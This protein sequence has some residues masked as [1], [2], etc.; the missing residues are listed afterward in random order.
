MHLRRSLEYGALRRGA[1]V[2]QWGC[3]VK[4]K[5]RGWALW[6]AVLGMLLGALA[7][8]PATAAP[9]D[10]PGAVDPSFT[11]TYSGF[12]ST[13]RSLV[14]QP[15]GKILAAGSFNSFNGASAPCLARFN[16]DWTIDTG[17]H[18]QSTC[19]HDIWSLALQPDGKILAS[20]PF[21]SYDNVPV[22]RVV[23][24]NSDGT[25]DPTFTA[26]GTGPDIGA[27]SLAVAP[28]GKII[29][30]GRFTTFDGTPTPGLARLEP[31]GTLDTAF[32]TNGG[33]GLNDRVADVAVQADGKVLAVGY[34]TA[35]DATTTNH[36]ARINTDGTLDTAF[37]ANGG[38]GL[39]KEAFTV[40]V[41]PDDKIVMGG[42]FTTYG[43]RSAKG[44]VRLESDGTYDEA[45]TD[46][47]P[48]LNCGI[49][50]LDL[51][52][53][54]IVFTGYFPGVTGWRMGRLDSGGAMDP[55]FNQK[56]GPFDDFPG[57]VASTGGGFVVG[58][59]FDA[60]D[61]QAAFNIAGF[62]ADGTLVP[63]PGLGFNDSVDTVQVLPDQKLLVGGI[64]D[65]YGSTPAHKVARLNPDG[66]LD[67]SFGLP[68]TGFKGRV[69]A[70][71]PL[72]NGDFYAGGYIT[73]FN[74]TPVSHL[75]RLHADGT[76]DTSFSQMGK[77]LDAA[78]YRAVVQPDGKLLVA[79]EFTA[80]DQTTVPHLARFNPDGS[81]DTAFTV[82]GGSGA[83]NPVSAVALLP[84]GKIVI[85]GRFTSFDGQKR[86]RIAR[87]NADGSLDTT[88]APTGAGFDNAVS[89]ITPQ[90]NG[91]LLVG[92]S[93][94][95][96]E[97]TVERYLA[98]LESDGSLDR[99]F[100]QTGRPIGYLVEAI[101]VDSNGRI[102]V[103]GM[104]SSPAKYLLRLNRD[105]ST[106]SSFQQT[107]S[108][109]SGPVYDL[110]LSANGTLVAVGYFTG[111][112]SQPYSRV[113]RLLTT[114]P[115]PS[116]SPPPTTPA[117]SPEPTST[118]GT[119]RT[120]TLK[121]SLPRR[122][123][124]DGVTVIT[125]A[126]ARTN[127]GLRPRTRV[128][129]WPRRASAAGDVRYFVVLRGNKGRVAIKTFGYPHLKFE[130]TQRAPST[131]EYRA[132]L[133]EAAYV[134]GHRE[135]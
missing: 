104:F 4:V 31:D 65:R 38:S 92:G 9:P 116:V 27:E 74:G 112:N 118:T 100:Q 87:L 46:A 13:V 56:G 84:D 126:G 88:F 25:V 20:G 76:L 89:A 119:R 98:R 49:V 32:S 123:K 35:F 66:T 72:L 81:L 2:E 68:G 48:A 30:G 58:G 77:G 57:T 18:Q 33:A 16:P 80:Y 108:G 122:I 133:R 127:A 53:D 55:D 61:G 1:W 29:L 117:P 43:G 113:I 3:T 41:Q 54:G 21:D 19:M 62:T 42:Y 15:D 40:A 73:D 69:I 83:N 36:V 125:P 8:N 39:N 107:G 78:V 132:F 22:A 111:Y 110:A 34:F 17:F 135:R 24:L 5:A 11:Q 124:R 12:N 114:A 82:A 131:A 75:A 45:F 64:F 120:Q 130:V 67:T 115:V 85:G 97:G 47:H 50:A 121:P 103:G 79:G 134:N 26:S 7:P 109:L 94:L 63:A 28:D 60:F 129:G 70:L 99:S 90:P 86:L 95:S 59:M 102:L 105:G 23:R 37:T 96:Y 106:D 51:Q 10:S 44:I 128:K 6:L 14:V 101:G 91:K 52:P 71:A 93:F